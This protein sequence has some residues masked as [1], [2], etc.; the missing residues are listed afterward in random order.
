MALNLLVP[1][2]GMHQRGYVHRDVKPA[3]FAIF[4]PLA[5]GTEGE[6]PSALRAERGRGGL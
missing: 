1:L 5:S 2:E 4:P 3:N 6:Q